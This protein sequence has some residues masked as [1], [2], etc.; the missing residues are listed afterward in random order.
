MS[1]LAANTP[2][3]TPARSGRNE[4][5]IA[6]ASSAELDGGSAKAARS[7]HGRFRRPDRGK[8]GGSGR[9]RNDQHIDQR[10]I[11]QNA[12]VGLAQSGLEAFLVHAEIGDGGGNDQGPDHRRPQHQPTDRIPFEHVAATVRRRS[13]EHRQIAEPPSSERDHGHGDEEDAGEDSDDRG[14]RGRRDQPS[15]V[16]P[17]ER[18]DHD[19]QRREI[20]EEDR[21]ERSRDDG[22]KQERRRRASSK[23]DQ[24]DLDHLKLSRFISG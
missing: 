7:G 23:S 2:D 16:A 21:R 22:S 18:G 24:D 19:R 5:A 15:Q 17:A 8:D 1:R 14:S 10:L 12:L 9:N 3:S 13:R 11:A 6:A 4:P 20:E